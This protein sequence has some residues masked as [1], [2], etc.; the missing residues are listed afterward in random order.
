MQQLI[1]DRRAELRNHVHMW[2]IVRRHGSMVRDK[3]IIADL[4]RDG[5][6]MR[7]VSSFRENDR[8]FL[9]LSTGLMSE[10]H[11]VRCDPRL[12]E[13]GCRFLYPLPLEMVQ[14]ILDRVE[15]PR[16]LAV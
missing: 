1:T 2:A 5:F 4:S 10:V 11:V 8:F 15:P 12:S 16:V 14:T 6:K 7:T 3:V 9:E 13:Y